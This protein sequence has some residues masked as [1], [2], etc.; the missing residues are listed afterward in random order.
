MTKVKRSQIQTFID[1]VPS[2]GLGSETYNLIG[3]GVPSGKIAY[4]PKTESVTYIHLDNASVSVESYAPTMA[5]EQVAINGDAI[6]EYIESL[7]IARAVLDDAETTIVNVWMYE[8]G[9]PAAYPAE[10]QPVCIAVED[11]GGDGG[12][13]VKL[14]YTIYYV[15][16]PIPG[17][18]N[19]S[20]K[21]FTA[22]A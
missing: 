21:A 13:A 11:Y 17:T 12:S 5:V 15:G 9:G 4:N 14:N 18:F 7:R 3:D 10:Q 1:T 20:T 16:D 8:T 19:A 6:F 2:G 22:T